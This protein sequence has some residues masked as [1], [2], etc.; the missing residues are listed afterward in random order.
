MI[1]KN[2]CGRKTLIKSLFSASDFVSPLLLIDLKTLKN[3]SAMTIKELFISVTINSLLYGSLIYIDNF[4]KLIK[5]HGDQ[6]EDIKNIITIL[7]DEINHLMIRNP[8]RLVFFA[9]DEKTSETLIMFDSINSA[10]DIVK[11][12]IPDLMLE[13]RTNA[14][15]WYLTQYNIELDETIY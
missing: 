9:M 7:M 11:I 4:D 12:K 1:G 2:K 8:H 6:S 5:N 10:Y 14:W 15:K 13:D 3:S